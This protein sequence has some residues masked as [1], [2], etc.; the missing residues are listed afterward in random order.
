LS[1]GR[2]CKTQQKHE[3][4]KARFV[5]GLGFYL[6]QPRPCGAAGG[7]LHLVL[8]SHIALDHL[9]RHAN[10]VGDLIDL[11]TERISQQD[12]RAA[13][14]MDCGIVDPNQTHFVPT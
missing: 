14:P 4:I 13:Q 12:A 8:K 1:D 3:N 11:T 7:N 2:F 9:A 5:H 10:V 6:E